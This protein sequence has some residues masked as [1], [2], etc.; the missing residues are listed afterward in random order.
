MGAF[1]YVFHFLDASSLDSLTEKLPSPPSPHHRDR[2]S[3]LRVSTAQRNLRLADR[4]KSVSMLTQYPIKTCY[5]GSSGTDIGSVQSRRH[6]VLYGPH[7]GGGPRVS[8]LRHLQA[9]KPSPGINESP[10]S[11]PHRSRRLSPQLL[12]YIS[13]SCLLVQ[14]I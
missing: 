10:L 11:S 3:L 5:I 4:Q 1:A 8:S 14:D 2:G 6:N 9:T 13:N 7:D 12:L